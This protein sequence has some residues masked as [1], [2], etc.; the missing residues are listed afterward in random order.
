MTL[1]APAFPEVAPLLQALVEHRQTVVRQLSGIPMASLKAAMEK[2]A[3]LPEV[4]AVPVSALRA[5]VETQVE[6]RFFLRTMY[7]ALTPWGRETLLQKERQDLK[8]RQESQTRSLAEHFGVVQ[9]EEASRLPMEEAAFLNANDKD[10][11][12]ALVGRGY[13][14]AMPHNRNVGRREGHGGPL[15]Y[16]MPGLAGQTVMVSD[17]LGDYFD[18]MPTNSHQLWDTVNDANKGLYPDC[19]VHHEEQVYTRWF[20]LLHETAHCQ[21][22]H[23]THPFAPSE[24]R[25]S[26]EQAAAMDRWLVGPLAVG[27][28][29]GRT[30]LDENHSDVLAAML[31]LE[32]TGHAPKALTALQRRLKD[33]QVV[34]EKADKEMLEAIG[35]GRRLAGEF[36]CVHATDFALERALSRADEWKG[37]SPERL[38]A[39]ACQ[40]ASD[41]LLDFLDVSR[42]VPTGE[43]VGNVLA[44]NFLPPEP[45]EGAFFDHLTKMVWS[46]AFG[47]KPLES[48]DHQS[49]PAMATVL[50]ALW[51]EVLPSLRK[52]LSKDMPNAPVPG[53]TI[54]GALRGLYPAAMVELDRFLAKQEVQIGL[55]D[56]PCFEEVRIAFHADRALLQQALGL[57]VAPVTQLSIHE[58]RASREAGLPPHEQEAKVSMTEPHPGAPRA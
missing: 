40:Y 15:A 53:Q 35:N 6:P 16:P 31:L 3:P 2:Q 38:R 1:P 41:G 36:A 58:W 29:N 44:N 52:E 14:S 4:P 50:A 54:G 5:W 47:G 18:G 42:P 57:P 24:G 51:E 8:E 48:L 17:R 11:V 32:A 20:V 55:Q 46:Y 43:N 39:L 27:S 28:R 25:M 56:Q 34:R 23:I 9:M 13:F 30:L 49:N 45:Q 10:L 21:F 37:A 22:Q 7:E 12:K 26:P 33:R 19:F